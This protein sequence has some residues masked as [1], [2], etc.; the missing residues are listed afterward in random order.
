MKKKKYIKRFVQLLAIIL[1][2]PVL[3]AFLAIMFYKKE[4]TELMISNARTTYGLD[5]HMEQ[6]KVSLFENWPNA[7]IEVINVNA[8]SSLAPKSAPAMF[9]AQSISIS[10]NL[11]KLLNKKFVVSSV[12]LKH[13]TIT[14]IKDKSGNTN[15]KLIQHSDTTKSASSLQFDL[16]KI[17]LTDIQLHFVNEERDKHI[18]VLFRNDI[19][20]LNTENKRIRANITGAIKIDELLFK[21]SK[22]PFLQNAEATIYLNTIIYPAYKSF[23]VDESSYAV[24]DEEKYSLVSFVQLDKEKKLTLKINVPAANFKKGVRLM[25]TKIQQDLAK[26]TV[27]NTVAI[28]AII[29]A[30][31]GKTEEPQLYVTMSGTDNNVTIGNTKIPYEH[32]SFTGYLRSVAEKGQEADLSKGEVVF[33]DIKGFV[34]DFPF[35]ANVVINDLKE[36][37]IRIKAGLVIEGPKVKFKPG[38]DFILNGLCKA[39]I[40]Y[41]GDMLHLNNTDFLN[42]PQQMLFKV[43]FKKFSYQTAPDQPAYVINGNADGLNKDIKFEKVKLETVGGDFEIA[44]TATDFVTYVLGYKNGFNASIQ[45]TTDYMNLTPMIAK[46]FNGDAKTAEP[47]KM[48]RREVKKA[49]DGAFAFS[50]SIFAK[51]LSIRF[52]NATDATVEMNYAKNTIEVKKLTMKACNGTLSATGKLKNFSTIQ[53]H[54]AIKNMNVKTMFEQFE[55]FGQTTISSDKLLG[56][57]SLTADMNASLNEKFQLKAPDLNGEVQLK[58]KDG[59]LLNFEPLKNIGTYFRK[60]DFT[61][62]TF[63]EINQNFKIKGTEM[64]I[65]NMEI[66]SSVLNL[67]IDG[68]YNFKGQTDLNLRI[69]LSNLK[70]RDK[71]YVPQELGKEGRT[72][73]ALRLNAH[74][75]P[76]KIKISLGAHSRDTTEIEVNKVQ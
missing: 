32:V 34:Y 19:I 76:N 51:K 50:M 13:G 29:V 14:F 56:T 3:V 17:N 45:A 65:Q 16:H 71:D 5:I 43:K 1:I 57:I 24:I 20:R 59:H 22:G 21:R 58:L 69:P 18:G 39:D 10:F 62:I 4:L 41:T 67:Y 42:A 31:I 70:A 53:A 15:Y 28:N 64:N 8:S 54:L 25:N 26:I 30:S 44:G 63:S 23:F 6:T 75:F 52:I 73:K 33:K 60:R 66:A 46:S 35:T 12:S 74:G 7:T 2:L 9:K 49:M 68:I 55:N 36:P 48:N 27:T 47:E 38:T 40:D 61:D 11:L 72:S 37:K